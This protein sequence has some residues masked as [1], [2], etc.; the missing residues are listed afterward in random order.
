MRIISYNL[1]ESH[2]VSTHTKSSMDKI[3]AT[4]HLLMSFQPDLIALQEYNNNDSDNDSYYS[5]L[6]KLF[7]QQGY[8]II[9]QNKKFHQINVIYYLKNKFAVIWTCSNKNRALLVVFQQKDLQ[10]M[11]VNVHLDALDSRIRLEQIVSYQQ[12]VDHCLHLSKM[13]ECE[14][15]QRMINYCDIKAHYQSNRH[16]DNGGDVNPPTINNAN[17]MPIIWLGDFNCSSSSQECQTLS[18]NGG[19]Q[20]IPIPYS[21]HIS[22]RT[23]DHVLL[24]Q[25]ADRVKINMLNHV[26]HL[27]FLNS[28]NPSDHLPIVFDV[29]VKE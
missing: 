12:T 29:L 10:F 8:S 26:R 9:K 27:G 19:L 3:N 18:S 1:Y 14:S 28:I 11:I 15:C 21:T 22:R 16:L 20:F 6:D 23:I 7:E 24:R 5:I 17:Q 4:F 13:I 2:N 25:N